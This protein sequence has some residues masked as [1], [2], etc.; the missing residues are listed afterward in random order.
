M[1]VWLGPLVLVIAGFIGYLMFFNTK[2]ESEERAPVAVADFINQ[3]KEEQLDGLSGMLITSLEQSRRLSVL[4]RSRMF[5]ILRVMGKGNVDRIDESSEE[6]YR[7]KR[8]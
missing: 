3:T 2:E 7:G 1:L 5:D 6:K 8:M 4:T